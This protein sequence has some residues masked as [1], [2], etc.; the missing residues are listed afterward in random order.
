MPEAVSRRPCASV[1][2][3]STASHMKSGVSSPDVVQQTKALDASS[4]A[5]A[6]S[7]A[8]LWRKPVS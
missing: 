1:S 8:R 7:A 3:A 2:A 4:P 6:S 5:G